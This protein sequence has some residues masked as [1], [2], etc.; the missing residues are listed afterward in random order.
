MEFAN[1][2]RTLVIAFYLCGDRKIDNDVGSEI[3]SFN[4]VN[5]RIKTIQELK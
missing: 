2:S 1:Y 5:R 4:R 3:N